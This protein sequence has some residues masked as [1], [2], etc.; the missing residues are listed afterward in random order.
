MAE[1]T[2]PTSKTASS[3]DK[4]PATEKKPDTK[5]TAK[6]TTPPQKSS[7]KTTTP[8]KADDK[9]KTATRSSSVPGS[10]PGKPSDSAADTTPKKSGGLRAALVVL[11]GIALLAGGAFATQAI[12]LPSVKPYL[13]NVPGFKPAPAPAP[14]GPSP[15]DLLTERLAALESKVT[16]AAETASDQ[17]SPSMAALDAERARVQGEL[18]KALT[19][20][21]DLENRLT[22]V[23]EMAQ[24][25]TS[26]ASGGTVDLEPVM[27]RIDS[28]EQSGRQ[29]S[30]DLAALSD[31]LEEGLSAP[32]MA[33]GNGAVSAAVLAI[34]Q[35]RDTALAGQPY[36]AQLDALQ[37]LVGDKPD[38]A[39]AVS[40]LDDTAA[41]GL[42]TAE[43][44]ATHFSG[45]A[46]EMIALARTGDGDWLDQ[47]TGQLSSLVSIRR[48]DGQSGDPVEDAVAAIEARLAA[49]DV[50]G[51]VE[52][53]TP[54]S[55]L[56]TGP[57]RAMLEP[58]LLDA[59][60]RATAER[61]LNALQAAALAGLGG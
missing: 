52:L 37:T 6:V 32:S 28:L 27:S 56:L 12:W 3:D 14:Q 51:A 59:K 4:K 24:A 49:R 39:A 35:L 55:D 16:A 11:V 38:V 41:V 2:K 22:E 23:R 44:L 18:D 53:A 61:A 48:T 42:P 54:L 21:G 25:L 31:R 17:A 29:T 46:G 10:G 30:A 19:R 5:S 20:I 1:P 43:Q 7:A 15:V 26:T 33:A 58:W 50:A 34:A 60:V 9:S 13:A 45:I 8:D 40:R 36:A 47:A 57:A